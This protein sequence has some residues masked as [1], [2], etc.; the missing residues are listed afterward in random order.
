MASFLF[1]HTA[2]SVRYG[3]C[4]LWPVR[5]WVSMACAYH[6]WMILRY[7]MTW[8]VVWP[9]IDIF[10][11]WNR[12][13]WYILYGSALPFE[14]SPPLTYFYIGIAA[15]DIFYMGL[16]YPLNDLHLWVIFILH[17]LLLIYFIWVCVILWGISTFDLFLF[18]LRWLIMD[19]ARPG[20]ALHCPYHA[21]AYYG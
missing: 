14:R 13:C 8:R 18:G 6:R 20:M 15:V 2:P 12:Y 17:S 19:M 9:Y 10:L 16:R 5:F 7:F 21:L 3:L 1:I 4:L 11:Y